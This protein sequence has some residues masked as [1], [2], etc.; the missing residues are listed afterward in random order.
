MFNPVQICSAVVTLVKYEHDTIQVTSVLIILQDCEK[1]DRGNWLSNPHPGVE[2]YYNYNNS[3]VLINGVME[4]C[5]D[6]SSF[7]AI[8]EPMLTSQNIGAKIPNQSLTSFFVS[9][10]SICLIE[11]TIR[12]ICKYNVWPQN[13]F[14]YTVRNY[15]LGWWYKCKNG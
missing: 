9:V 2:G 4:A 13:N 1:T 5:Y 7:C 3:F 14:I 12:L 11:I 6:L 8:R 10:I 15:I